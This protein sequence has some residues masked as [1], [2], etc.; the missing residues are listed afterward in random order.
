MRWSR[1]RP[2][3]G[4]QIAW[5]LFDLGGARLH[6]DFLQQA[7]EVEPKGE[8][9]QLASGHPGPGLRR[10]IPVEFHAILVRVAQVERLADAV[11]ARPVGR[12]T[13][14]DETPEGVGE[15]PAGGIE[16]GDVMEPVAPA[17]G[18]DPP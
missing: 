16:D 14:G 17:G 9:R 15:G 7:V 1:A 13:F 18:G 6:L 5:T 11:I 8:H 4:L 3:T 10:S 12:D 2:E